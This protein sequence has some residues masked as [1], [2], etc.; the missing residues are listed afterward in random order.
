MKPAG[1]F[2]AGRERRHGAVDIG[3]VLLQ[4][5]GLLGLVHT[6]LFRALVPHDPHHSCANIGVVLQPDPLLSTLLRLW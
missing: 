6:P 2:G 5:A 4:M 1:Y 3:K